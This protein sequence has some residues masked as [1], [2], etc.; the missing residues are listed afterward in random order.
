MTDALGTRLRRAPWLH[1]GAPAV[2]V[3]LAMAG[4][5]LL[6]AGASGRFVLLPFVI[7]VAACST[8]LGVA[9]TGLAVA[10]SALALWMSAWGEVPGLPQASLVFLAT[11]ALLLWNAVRRDAE[12][13]AAQTRR[14]WIALAEEGT[15]IGIWTLEAGR[16][17]LQ[18]SAGL[19]RLLGRPAV[20]GPVQASTWREWVQVEDRQDTEAQIRDALARG[21]REFEREFRAI[22]PDGRLRPLI[23][24]IRINVDASGAPT[25]LVGTTLPAIDRPSIHQALLASIVESSEDAIISKTLAGRITSWNAGATRLYGWT[26]AEMVGQSILTIVPPR[27]HGE[28]EAILARLR[29]GERLEHYET[30]RV[31]KDGSPRDVS[32]TIS[33]VRDPSGR[34]VGASKVARDVSGRRRQEAERQEAERRKDEF[35]ALLSHELRNPLAPIRQV[36]KLFQDPRLSREQFEWGTGVLSRQSAQLIVLLDDLLSLSRITRG[37]LPLRRV[38]DL[39]LERPLQ[40][41]IETTQARLEA[42][43]QSLAVEG[44]ECGVTVCGDP[45][46]L[47]QVFTSLLDNASRYSAPGANLRLRVARDPWIAR[48]EVE[49]DGEGIEP[50]DLERVFEMF[51][52]RE[53]ALHGATPGLGI[54][55]GLARQLVQMHGGR[56]TAASAGRGRG[57]TFTVE[58]PRTAASPEPSGGAPG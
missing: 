48:V 56:I 57:S 10:L 45:A 38:D 32:L 55:L 26:E 40:M 33:P 29:N 24:R 11:S 14:E 9:A 15:G 31:A 27:L 12:R 28:E 20:E 21:E 23:A 50:G 8:F 41:A 17:E 37:E 6:A 16:G 2:A 18:A 47:A 51:W 46:R 30:E 5:E 54:G 13:R 49:D 44:L 52:R 22:L 58:L 39:A 36:A 34:V 42:R 35:I 7:A 4:S 19:F 1:I 53:S 25:T 3:A 43:G